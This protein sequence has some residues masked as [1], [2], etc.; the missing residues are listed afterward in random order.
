MAGLKDD[1]APFSLPGTIIGGERPDIP[2]TWINNELE[3]M[4]A[5][6]RDVLLMLLR[7]ADLVFEPVPRQ[8]AFACTLSEEP[9]LTAELHHD[10]KNVSKIRILN[11]DEAPELEIVRPSV[12]GSADFLARHQRQI[13]GAEQPASSSAANQA[14]QGLHAAGA[15]GEESPAVQPELSARQQEIRPEVPAVQPAPANLGTSTVAGFQLSEEE[16]AGIKADLSA[17]NYTFSGPDAVFQLSKEEFLEIGSKAGSHL[18]FNAL[19]AHG[20][21]LIASNGEIRMLRADAIKIAK[22]TDGAP[23]INLMVNYWKKFTDPEGRILMTRLSMIDSAVN[24]G[25][26][27]LTNLLN[28]LG[29]E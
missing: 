2:S 16:L 24:R 28:W 8:S 15:G 17:L 20:K 10:G 26:E 3:S 21:A 1:G 4:N 19:G 27:H 23:T 18:T 13:E 5:R 12:P 29:D 14:E 9:R 25:S 22:R 6:Q 7:G 11:E